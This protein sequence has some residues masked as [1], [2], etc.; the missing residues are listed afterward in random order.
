V[1]EDVAQSVVTVTATSAGSPSSDLDP[2]ED[3]LR[4]F[5]QR[6]GDGDQPTPDLPFVGP[7]S[8]AAPV[9]AV[10]SGFVVE[11]EGL[12]VTADAL[13]AD[14]DQIEVT[15]PDGSS[16][17]AEIVGR[18]EQTGVALLRVEIQELPGISW[19]T[20]AELGLGENLLSVG[21]TEEFGSVLSTGLLAG[22]S[23]DGE[24]LLIDDAP[25]SALLGSPVLDSQGRIVAIRTAAED[26]AEIGAT[27]ALASD[28]ARDV[29]DELARSGVVAR[30]YLGIQIQPVTADIANALGL[31]EPKG[32]LVAEVQPDTPAA[33]AGL[34]DGDVILSVEGEAV[35]EPEALSKTIGNRDPGQEVRLQVWRADKEVEMVATL[36]ALP[37]QDAAPDPSGAAEA[38]VPVPE[39]G[40][41]LQPLTPDLR[42]ALGAAEAVQGVAVLDVEDPSRSDIQQGDVIVSV[43]QTR[44]ET[45]EDL[46]EAVKAARAD[47]QASVLLLIDRRGERS[48]V[49]MD[50]TQS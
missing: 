3:F 31:G 12:I 9:R 7:G 19:G 41:T 1:L 21:R 23:A 10:G 45:V 13:I 22:R 42:D 46:R 50:L 35:S 48:F 29:V 25:A 28:T 34:Q 16:Q 44:V 47:G 49:P 15:L 32:V 39:L 26:G 40:L 8:A 17:P 36:A 18:D 24:R 5:L 11:P 27:V 14:A 43:H 6:F 20:S 2:N 30:G 4:E 33:T 38:G 37:A